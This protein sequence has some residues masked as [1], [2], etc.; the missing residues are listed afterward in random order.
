LALP[1]ALREAQQDD[2]VDIS[3]GK[4]AAADRHATLFAM[5]TS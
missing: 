1:Q 5:R 2:G 4:D 3:A